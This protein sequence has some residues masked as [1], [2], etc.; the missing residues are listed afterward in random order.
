MNQ[1]QPLHTLIIGAGLTG[2]STAHYLNKAGIPF[3][4]LEKHDDPGGVMK[5]LRHKDFVY[6]TG[7]N[8]GV[9]GSVEIAELFEDL[10][11]FCTLETASE[12]VSKRYILKKGQWHALP[13]GLMGGIKTPLFTLK[14]KFRLLGEPFR[15]RGQNPHETLAQLVIRRMGQ[16]FLDYAIDPFILGVYAGDPAL[17]VPK[18]A[19]PKLYTLEQKYGSFIGG[20]IT[21]HRE[22]KD[23]R[24]SKVSRKVFSVQNGLSDLASALYRSAGTENFM[25]QA[26]SITVS[27][28]HG[29]Y[30]VDYEV[31]GQAHRIFTR[32]LV[33]TTPA[34]ALPKL[35]PFI[36]EEQMQKLTN[37]VYAPVLEVSL[38]F[39]QWK[40][41]PLDGFGGLIP[42]K[43]DRDILGVLFMSSL[44]SDRA[45]RDGA[46]LTVF[47]GGVRKKQLT[48]LAD[49]EIREL[50]KREIMDLMQLS[51]FNPSLFHLVRY[52]GAIPQYAADSGLRFETIDQLQAQ[53]PGLQLGGNMRDG[54][55]MADRVKQARMLAEK[56]IQDT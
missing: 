42:H 2:L 34:F 56:I 22:K 50:V 31:K 38:G 32:N 4:V 53:Y 7:P 46:L 6:E 49:E 16:S 17:L 43:E 52:P 36:A 8:T 27:P 1:D 11:G 51:D 47:L 29:L 40:G 45:P 3:K 10:S 44:F 14:D 9:I 26:D 55:G 19:L 41:I 30:R 15:A 20:A 28:M 13:S 24:E 25:F 12:K 33:T 35:L 21:K 48:Q 23:P 37:L 18:Y 54:I 5:T 39:E